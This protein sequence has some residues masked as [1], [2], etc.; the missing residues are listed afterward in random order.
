MIKASILI[1]CLV[2][3]ICCPASAQP[4]KPALPY[5]KRTGVTGHARGAQGLSG[6]IARDIALLA[7][8]GR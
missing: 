2:M 3:T 5:C 1:S 6:E 7:A 4:G 8:L